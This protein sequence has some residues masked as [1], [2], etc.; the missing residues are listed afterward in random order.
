MPMTQ[1]GEPLPGPEQVLL[2]N[3]KA[4]GHKTAK[5]LDR[6]CLELSEVGW[7]QRAMGEALSVTFQ[8]IH[9][10]VKKAKKMR[11]VLTLDTAKDY[12]WGVDMPPLPV[13]KGYLD[14]KM[15][16]RLHRLAVRAKDSV[17]TPH[18]SVARLA[19]LR[20]TALMRELYDDG[21]PPH[22]LMRATGLKRAA[23]SMR[24]LAPR[25]KLGDESEA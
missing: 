2:R 4:G 13:P 16:R 7:T 23:T 11:A 10:R 12:P 1:L 22:V 8:S 18:G 21:V 19:S 17:K 25:V 15:E 14:A 3:L 24:L 6:R 5:L 20:L 9:G